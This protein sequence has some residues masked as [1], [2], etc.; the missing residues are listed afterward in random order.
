MLDLL[1]VFGPWRT[2]EYA[3]TSPQIKTDPEAIELWLKNYCSRNPT[4]YF[5]N[6]PLLW[7]RWIFVARESFWGKCGRI[8]LLLERLAASV[9]FIAPLVERIDVSEQYCGLRN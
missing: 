7:P 4:N 9:D 8:A 3:R 2:N 1:A 6:A 5:L